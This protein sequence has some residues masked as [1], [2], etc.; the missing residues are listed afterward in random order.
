MTVLVIGDAIANQREQETPF[1]AG[2]MFKVAV[3]LAHLAREVRMVTDVSEASDP[4]VVR[5]YAAEHGVELLLRPTSAPSSAALASGLPTPPPA[6]FT[7]AHYGEGHGDPEESW[8]ILPAPERGARKLD[9]DLFSP[10]ATIFGGDACHAMP[11]AHTVREWLRVCRSTST[12]IYSPA[13]RHPRARNLDRVRIQAESFL[14]LSDV[15][16]A[17]SKDIRLLYGISGPENEFAAVAEHWF[18]F[19]PRLVAILLEDGAA[20]MITASGDRLHVASLPRPCVDVAGAR[21]A[22]IATTIDTLDRVSLLGREASPGL[23]TM[24]MSHLYT[25]GAFATTA[26]SLMT[27]HAGWEPLT[28]NELSEGF[29]EYQS[30]EGLI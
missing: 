27:A 15:V 7:E 28:R 20:L 1:R 22:F 11:V 2:T 8:D 6:A 12:I 3:N 19:G 29:F 14:Q 24:S 26:R 10:S 30:R 23:A 25:V 5:D 21:S 16:V 18:S 13:L 17:T 9:F 4:Q